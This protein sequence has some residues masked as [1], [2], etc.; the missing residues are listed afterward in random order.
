MI[1]IQRTK[2]FTSPE[3]TILLACGRNREL[4]EQPFQACTMDADCIKPDGQNSVISFV[5][6]NGCTQSSRFLPQ[7]R[8]IV[9][10]GDKNADKVWTKIYGHFYFRGV[11]FKTMMS[12]F[13]SLILS[14]FNIEKHF[15]AVTWLIMNSK[16]D[17]VCNT[18]G[19]LPCYCK[20]SVCRFQAVS[21]NWFTNSCSF[22]IASGALSTDGKRAQKTSSHI[23][24]S[25]TQKDDMICP[26]HASL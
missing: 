19:C 7:A 22:D 5:F 11:T 9:G 26:V 2:S 23:V 12:R 10:S 18:I 20:L 4:W 14:D 6:Q 15:I 17:T 25:Y 1:T 3:P 13:G 24:G 8:R 21:P 16:L